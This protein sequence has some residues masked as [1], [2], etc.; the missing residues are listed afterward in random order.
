M[1]KK[2]LYLGEE[3]NIYGINDFIIY[4]IVYRKLYIIY[5]ILYIVYRISKAVSRVS[6]LCFGPFLF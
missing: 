2:S 4:E 6:Y 3:K 5:C 1:L